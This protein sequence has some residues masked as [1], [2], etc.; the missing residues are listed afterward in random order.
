M[1]VPEPVVGKIEPVTPEMERRAG[2]TVVELAPGYLEGQ[3]DRAAIATVLKA[4]GLKWYPSVDAEEKR[5]RERERDR[6]RKTEK[7]TA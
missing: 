7:R 1:G 2:K 4:L 3:P 6:R 5:R